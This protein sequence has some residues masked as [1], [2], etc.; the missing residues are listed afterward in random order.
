MVFDGDIEMGVRTV[1]V[2]ELPGLMV[3]DILVVDR[4]E[5]HFEKL[6][7]T[8]DRVDVNRI[9][10]L[11]LVLPI[12]VTYFLGDSRRTVFTLHDLVILMLLS[13]ISLLLSGQG[14]IHFGIKFGAQGNLEDSS[15][16][17]EYITR[18]YFYQD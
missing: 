9:R 10:L 3:R 5:C 13:V 18:Y 14:K 11:R 6:D 8:F 1:M 17:V 7:A 4:S 15:L 2:D 12:G 16:S